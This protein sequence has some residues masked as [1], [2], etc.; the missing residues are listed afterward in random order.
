MQKDRPE[1][2]PVYLQAA[3]TRVDAV[4]SAQRAPKRPGEW[5]V[6]RLVWRIEGKQKQ[7]GLGRIAEDEVM[8]AAARV[9]REEVGPG[10][11]VGTGR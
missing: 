8:A 10:G 1:P 4:L 11:E 7:R 5:W 2:I 9:W 6:W 3:G